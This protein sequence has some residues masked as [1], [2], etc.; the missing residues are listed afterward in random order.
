MVIYKPEIICE[1]SI[2]IGGLTQPTWLCQSY[3]GKWTWQHASESLVPT[4]LGDGEP[5]APLTLCLDPHPALLPSR[6]GCIARL[7]LKRS[8][9]TSPPARCSPPETL[10]LPPVPRSL[11]VA[12]HDFDAPK[13]QRRM[14]A[15]HTAHAMR[16]LPFLNCS[17][18]H[19]AS[20]YFCFP[21]MY[22]IMH[23]VHVFH[24]MLLVYPLHPPPCCR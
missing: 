6:S 23:I 17:L 7:S 21:C 24:H 14:R 5:Q 18:H 11:R 16:R 20:L 12:E 3:I 8:E 1:A 22:I 19:A 13:C 15:Q 2:S 4:Q 10:P 9:S